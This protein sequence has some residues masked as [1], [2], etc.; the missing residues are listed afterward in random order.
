MK[1]KICGL[2]HPDNIQQV[3][4]QNPDFIGFIFYDKSP[5]F[6][7]DKKLA[8]LLKEMSPAI[9]KTGVFVNEDPL[10]IN[11]IV[12]TYELGAV[13]LH[14]SETAEL[15]SKFKKTGLTVI[16]AFGIREASDFDQIESYDGSCDYFLFDTKTKKHGGSGESFNWELLKF[17]SGKT[18]FLLS[19]GIGIGDI[20]EIKNISH[21][22][23]AGID[24]NSGF[25]IEP[26]L[27]D[28]ELIK[29]LTSKLKKV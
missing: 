17:Y 23:F 1:L 19:G 29:K 5:R 26:G 10:K 22:Q 27:K 14:G 12:S 25:E 9:I 20:D 7:D 15:C 16:K 2:K 18:A 28:I 21:P 13:Q 6:V 3:A 8:K 4:E 24:V 11:E